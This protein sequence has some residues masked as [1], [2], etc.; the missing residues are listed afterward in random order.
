MIEKVI[1]KPQQ[2]L[3]DHNMET[4]N[5][6]DFFVENGREQSFEQKDIY[7]AFE[8]RKLADLR[9]NPNGLQDPAKLLLLCPTKATQQ[10][11]NLAL[12]KAT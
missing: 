7:L 11:A 9:E 10:R 5:S 6:S 1:H 4:I 8:H 3:R 2:P 12:L